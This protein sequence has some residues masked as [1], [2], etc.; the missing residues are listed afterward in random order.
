MRQSQLFAPTLK[1]EPTEAEIISHK[2]ML[3]AGMLRKIAGGIYTFLPL[4]F[5]VLKK[6]ENIVRQEMNA[7]GAQELLMPVLQPSELWQK[8]GRWYAYG[9]EMMRM[10]D[11]H[12]RDFALGPT[13]EEL[14][15]HLASEIRSYKELPKILYQIQVKFRDEVRP[16]FGVMRS[17]EFI[18]KDAYSFHADQNSLDETYQKMHKAYSR[19]VER[20][21]LSY[22]AVKAATGLIGGAVS[23]EFQVLA[24]TGE[25][26]IIYCP[27]CSYAA[28][29]EMASSR[30]WHLLEPDETLAAR[31]KIHT[32]GKSSVEDVAKLLGVPKSKLVKTLIYQVDDNRLVAVLIPGHKNLNP[33]KLAR[34]LETEFEMLE[35][36]E[37]SKRGLAFGF[38]GPIDLSNDLSNIEIIADHSLKKM[39]NFVTG[40]NQKDYHWINSNVER[41]FLIDK[42]ADLVFAEENEPCSECGKGQLKVM[43]GIEVGQIFQLGTK[44]SEKMGGT[45][46]DQNGKTKPF[47]MGCYGIGVSRLVAA[48]IEQLS[49]EYGIIWPMSIAPYQV[50]L[51]LVGKEDK[52]KQNAEEIYESLLEAKVEALYDDR[53]ISPGIKFSEA[54][55]I[56]IPLQV[57]IGKK[58]LNES[59]LEVKERRTNK[60]VTIEPDKLIK[61]IKNKIEHV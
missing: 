32:P 16:R 6:V 29:I 18:M 48:A 35:E 27:K 11:R 38:V 7:V 13:H 19:I 37:F 42:W 2:L 33:T 22:R 56:G 15:T 9:Q 5:R 4:G 20:C 24:E 55:L 8:S 58:F 57:I 10:K 30:W 12:Q 61:W 47:V 43:Q 17:R 40:A 60:R 52:L 50:H 28:N 14:I 59:K 34:I 36:E 1:E 46:I 39:R 41:D 51:L 44:Y 26:T 49:D 21:G 54:D 31:E 23:E 25:D 3:R 45:F 53:Q